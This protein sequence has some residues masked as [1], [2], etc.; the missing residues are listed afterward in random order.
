MIGI[1]WTDCLGRN[2]SLK[3]TS[4]A[5]NAMHPSGNGRSPLL[6]TYLSTEVYGQNATRQNAT[7]ENATRTKCHP[8]S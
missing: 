8:G 2:A 6:C 5:V 4:S 7:L 3:L 1:P